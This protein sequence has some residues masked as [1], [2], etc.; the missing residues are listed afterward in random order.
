MVGRT[1]IT[2]YLQAAMRSASLRQSIIANNIANVNTPE[3]RRKAIAFEKRLAEAIAYG[4]RVNFREI[5]ESIFEPR[6]TNVDSSGNDVNLEMEIG[7]MIKNGVMY[8]AYTRLL[9]RTYRNM[10]LAMRDHY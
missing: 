2:E 4:E 9:G 1:S 3:Y 6:N 10:E 7:E 8:K 5:E